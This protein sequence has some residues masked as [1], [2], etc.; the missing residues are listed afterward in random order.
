M[1]RPRS[2]IQPRILRAAR[3]RFLG[4]G[5]DAA[6]LR[7]IASDAQTSIGMIDYY[8]P[9]K[10]DLFFAV[11]EEAYEAFLRDLEAAIQPDVSVEARLERL[12][13]RVARVSD[14]ELGVM[15][16]V[17]REV[18]ASSSRLDRLLQRFLRGH[19]PLI[20]RLVGDGFAAGAFER[21]LHPLLVMLSI[22]GIS[23][24]PQV[25]R[26]VMGARLPPQLLESAPSGDELA[27][28]LV[29]VLFH[30]VAQKS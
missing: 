29:H 23:I 15:Q 12:S 14:E 19:V 4:D 21:T 20:A 8:F 24:V 1:P 13:L 11:V 2:D 25:M 3:A 28:A 22:A 9:T 18:L 27:R 10:D 5:V 17:A 6:S 7:S 16:L 30:G 26:R